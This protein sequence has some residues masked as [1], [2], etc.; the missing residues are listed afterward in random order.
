MSL[1]YPD[2]LKNRITDITPDDLKKLGVCGLLLDVDNTLTTHGSQVL[3]P[4]ISDWIDNMK[5]LGFIPTIVSNAPPGRVAPFAKRLGL[6]YISFACKPF[7]I[8]FIR[9]ARRLGLKRKECV[10][11]GDQTFTDIIGANLAGVHS[12][13][14]LPIL[15][16]HQIT[17]RFKRRFEGYILKRYRK[18]QKKSYTNS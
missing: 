17:L 18:K 4:A 10:A 11:I 14:L 6:R 13:Q 16:E 12:I 2:M 1:L 8:G 7:P 3:D 5:S 15:P 9:G